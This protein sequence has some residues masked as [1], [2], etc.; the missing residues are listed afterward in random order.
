MALIDDFL[1]KVSDKELRQAKE[2]QKRLLQHYPEEPHADCA[3]WA[4]WRLE[5]I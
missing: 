5:N 3:L 2:V 4:I 1:G